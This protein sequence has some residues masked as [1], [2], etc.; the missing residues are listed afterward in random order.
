MAN[1]PLSDRKFKWAFLSI[2]IILGSLQYYTLLSLGISEN[3][4]L[5]DSVVSN[6]IL[7]LVCWIIS[8]VF[9]YY[10]PKGTKY[11]YVIVL[12]LILSAK[13]AA[14]IRY[15]FFKL[16]SNDL[17]Y[18]NII[19]TSLPIRFAFCFLLI[20]CMSAISILYY[21][22]QDHQEL[23]ERKNE[24]EKLTRDAE[25]SSLR[26]KLQ[27]HFLFNSLNSI[28]ALTL[29]KPQE[30]RKMVQQLSDFLRGTIKKNDDLTNLQSELEHL[31][32]YLE[33]EK[34]RFG[35]RLNTQILN[36]GESLLKLIPP[37]L[38]Q[39]IVE[40]AIKFGLYDTLD[41]VTIQIVTSFENPYLK[42]NISNPFDPE[43]A[44]PNKGTGFGLNSTQRRLALLYSRTDLLKTSITKN[45]FTTTIL[46]PQTT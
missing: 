12:C 41:N 14:I 10:R 27:P 20:G 6:A 16:I 9:Y 35:N 11:I 33:I 44:H 28:S 43:T 13:Y 21:N 37:M 42:I 22:Q 29:S 24:A 26:E 8:N 7:G 15:S 2:L 40:N 23:I 30:A 3:V 34:V 31:D 36:D 17:I 32:L 45:T 1:S 25:L 19:I 46:I 5:K 39:P 38:L 4:A 18:Q